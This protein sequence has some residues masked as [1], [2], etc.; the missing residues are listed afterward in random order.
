M[1]LFVTGT[2][3]HVG[4][5]L[6]SCALLHCFAAQGL[7]VVGMKPVAAGVDT[8]GVNEDVKL[9]MAA[10]SFEADRASVN[11][12]SFAAAIAPHLAARQE[13]SRI[14]LS[15]IVT[16][17]HA[18]QAVADVVIVE[19]AGGFVVPLNDTQD[20]GDLAEQL[21]LPVILVVG[22]RL[23][24]L[25]HALLTAQAIAA[26]GLKLV[27]WVANGVDEHM[28]MRDDNIAALQ[29]RLAAPLLGIIPHQTQPDA[30][31]VAS[32]LNVALCCA[33]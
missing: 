16:S 11:P 18:L 9:L 2:D 25:N 21:A 5:T 24:C 29:Q 31:R 20:S 27:G 10:S 26:R 15:H 4:K 3:T 8:D 1:S 32:C 33:P 30:Q 12:Y 6:V 14:D 17:F 19:G 28:A 13:N 22:M 23:G 7:R